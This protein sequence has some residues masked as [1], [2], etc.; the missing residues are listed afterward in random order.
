MQLNLIH[1][2]FLFLSFYSLSFI[3]Q[4][5]YLATLFHYRFFKFMFCLSI[6][7]LS[8]NTFIK[9]LNLMVCFCEFVPISLLS[10][11]QTTDQ[12]LKLGIVLFFLVLVVIFRKSNI[13]P[14]LYI[15][16]RFHHGPKNRKNLTVLI[17]FLFICLT[18]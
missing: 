10:L 18:Q 16:L 14:F 5:F 1:S 7:L 17:H 15:L 11:K 13:N 12:L 9:V 8:G 3:I 4:S 6:S 2:Y